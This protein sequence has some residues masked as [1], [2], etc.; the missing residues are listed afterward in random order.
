[1]IR[2][3][4]PVKYKNM[5]CS[6]LAEHII[7]LIPLPPEYHDIDIEEKN[8]WGIFNLKSYKM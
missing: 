6:K 1:M 8:K 4:G 3:Y 5:F 7:R 2:R